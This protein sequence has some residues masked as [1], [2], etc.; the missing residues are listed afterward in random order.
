MDIGLEIKILRER[1]Q[2]S[3][4]ELAEKVGLSPSQV[5]RL[6]KGQR[7]IDTQI[8]NKIAQALDV[9]PAFFF[10]D[11]EGPPQDVDEGHVYRDIGRLI[12]IERR[13]RHLS[14]EEFAR[15]IAKTKAFVNAVEEGRRDLLDRETI[16][17]IGKALRVEPTFFFEAQQGIIQSLKQKILRLEREFSDK[18]LGDIRPGAGTW[19][20]RPVPILGELP[21]AYPS[22]FD[23]SGQ[24]VDRVADYV[25][26]PGVDAESSFALYARG[27]SM[28][29]IE[30]PAFREGDIL[31][32][33]AKAAIRSRDFAFTRPAAGGTTFRQVF[34][35]P[36]GTV[37]LQPLNLA[38]PA[39]VFQK[40]EVI[41][42]WRLVAHVARS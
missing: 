37:R 16:E 2:I 40:E 19:D 27:D 13:R 10:Q 18:T 25:F 12:R 7:R 21:G 36:N 28:D 4:K 30:A 39:E 41:R 29:R 38:Y 14:S 9:T 17:R 34:F 5:S 22:T 32:F 23:E 3:A 6:E 11:A 24:P 26:V 42:M 31:V 1:K 8:L 35:D 20:R 15:K 33:S